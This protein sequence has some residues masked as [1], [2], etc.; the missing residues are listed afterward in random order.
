MI[1][2]SLADPLETQRGIIRCDHCEKGWGEEGDLTIAEA[3]R[4]FREHL[5][6]CQPDLKPRSIEQIREERKR[7]QKAEERGRARREVGFSGSK[8]QNPKS[9]KESQS[10]HG[11]PSRQPP[12]TDEMIERMRELYS[13]TGLIAEVMRRCY[14]EFGFSSPERLKNALCKARRERKVI[15]GIPRNRRRITDEVAR[16]VQRL[17]KEE[18]LSVREITRRYYQDCGYSFNGFRN[19]VYDIL[20]KSGLDP[21]ANATRVGGNRKKMTPARVE[22]AWQLYTAGNYTLKEIEEMS[23][24]WWSVDKN[25]IGDN[26]K[27][28]NHKLRAG[29][30]ENDGSRPISK[31]EAAE[32]IKSAG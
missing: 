3:S 20:R 21:K 27:R 1:Y 32:L 29:K 8:S 18:G 7:Q 22:T 17:H 19:V 24:E 13:E 28:A 14:K 10:R 5:A 26:L 16:E 4:Q 6:Q 11:P 30:H 9:E 2:K 25:T 12:L 31:K 15:I 23:K